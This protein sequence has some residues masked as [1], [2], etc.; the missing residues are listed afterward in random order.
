MKANKKIVASVLCL[1]MLASLGGCALFDKDD[2]AVLAV[3]DEYAEAV[4][5][6]KVSDVAELLVDGEDAE[7]ELNAFTSGN[8]ADVIEEYGD[9]CDAIA[10]TLSYEIDTESVE[11]S[12]KNAEASVTVTYTV[13]DYEAV[14]EQVKED[15]GDAQDLINALGDG[16]TVEIEQTMN[17]E[18]VDGEWLVKDKKNKNLE[19]VWAFY[20]DAAA[21]EFVPP[22]A[23]YISEAYFWGSDN[24]VFTNADRIELDIIPTEEGQ[25][26][27]WEFTYEWYRD[28]DLI[29]TSSPC[30]D[31][32]YYIEAYYGTS[33]DS[34]AAVNDYGYLVPG[35]YRCVIYD[36]AGNVLADDTCTV[37]ATEIP[38]GASVDLIEE[39]YFW[40]SDDGVYTDE[41]TIELDIIPTTEGQMIE[42]RFTYEWYYEGELIFTSD[43]CSDQGYYIES[44]YGPYQDPNA[45]LTDDGYLV[46]GEYSCIVYDLDGNVLASGTCTVR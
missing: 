20:G 15:G 2:E 34:Q 39:A 11:S 12:K 19:E 26:I 22:L 23:S 31:Q 6:A 33:Y 43:E 45:Q 36:L 27:E 18:L 35:Q 5:K 10:D 38:S 14:Y 40:G 32:G 28:G 8:G 21:F 30:S 44:Y 9:I 24:G 42:W 41:D 17:L 29:F 25:E 46:P 37:E 4:T 3:A 7:D 16:D 1:S 13:V